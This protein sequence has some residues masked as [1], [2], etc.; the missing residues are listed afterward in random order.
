MVR[1]LLFSSS[2]N[3]YTLDS[4]VP[5]NPNLNSS[6]AVSVTYC[7]QEEWAARNDKQ[8]GETQ[9]IKKKKTF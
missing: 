7:N 3:S 8:M 5:N 2:L 9:I 4:A 1:F 6:S